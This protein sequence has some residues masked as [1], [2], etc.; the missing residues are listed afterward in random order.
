MKQAH[1]H[2]LKQAV[3]IAINL[4]DIANIQF[5]I[6]RLRSYRPPIYQLI[7]DIASDPRF[8]GITEDTPFWHRYALASTHDFIESITAEEWSNP[9]KLELRK[10]DFL[11]TWHIKHS[12]PMTPKKEKEIELELQEKGWSKPEPDSE[13]LPLEWEAS[14]MPAPD[15]LSF[16]SNGVTDCTR[17]GSPTKSSDPWFGNRKKD[18][19]PPE[20]KNFNSDMEKIEKGSPASSPGMMMEPHNA[21][22][23]FLSKIDPTLKK[24]AKMIGRSGSGSPKDV[25]GKFQHSRRSDISG[26]TVGND[27]GSL[28]PTELALLGQQQTEDIFY[29]KYAQKQLQIFSSS[30]FSTEQSTE[31]KGAIFMCIDTSGSMSGEPEV[32]AKSL[33][34]AI[35]II[36]Q[37]EHRPLCVVNYS[38]E[39]SFFILRNLGRQ[40]R[41][42]MKFL[43]LSYSGGN[44]ENRL[45]RFLF[46]LLPNHPEYQK[47][48]RHF[49]KADLLVISDFAW[50]SLHQKIWQLIRNQKDKGMIF[51]ALGVNYH[52]IIEDSDTFDG[53]YLLPGTDFFNFCDHKFTSSGSHVKEA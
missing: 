30:S 9:E 3:N 45:F 5:L 50:G 43:S 41:Q 49:K 14:E 27:L 46:H 28:L 21:E 33:C 2:Y 53:E 15:S 38:D 40:R 42:F 24:L 22:A 44:N 4:K 6:G 19:L 8:Y 25:S 48:S 20:I 31:K 7:K 17:S 23:R 52:S 39:V 12:V 1:L 10:E 18:D 26:I 47:F 29:R 51:Y 13:E 37:R 11:N 32:M 36:A 16:D 34:L 35:A